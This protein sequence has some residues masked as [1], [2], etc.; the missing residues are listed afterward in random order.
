M[1]SSFFGKGTF[2]ANLDVC[3]LTRVSSDEH[4]NPSMCDCDLC[5]GL[6]PPP[7]PAF[8]ASNAFCISKVIAL[9]T[10]PDDIFRC[11][12]CRWSFS[13]LLLSP[14]FLPQMGHTFI[15]GLLCCHSM[16]HFPCSFLSRSN[17]TLAK[18]SLGCARRCT[19]FSMFH[20]SMRVRFFLIIR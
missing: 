6:S 19:F 2:I 7:R 10:L 17:K 20:A 18:P 11:A 12:F 13:E 9:S 4:Q 14:A 3:F 16:E 5:V 8:I 15:V 1:Q